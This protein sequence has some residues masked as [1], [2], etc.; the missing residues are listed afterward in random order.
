MAEQTTVNFQ[1][2]YMAHACIYDN[3]HTANIRMEKRLVVRITVAI[4]CPCD[5]TD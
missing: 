3:I 5:I 4:V 1:T 2:Q